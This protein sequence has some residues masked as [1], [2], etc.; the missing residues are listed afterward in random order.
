MARTVGL[1]AAIGA[2]M[3]L[4]EEVSLTSVHIPVLPEIYVPVLGDL[5]ELGITCE[6]KTEV[7]E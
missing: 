1:P 5:E 6:E 3:I 7:L 4:E 2:R